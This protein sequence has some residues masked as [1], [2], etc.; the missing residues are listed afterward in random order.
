MT[1]A[2]P[3]ASAVTTPPS[4]TSPTIRRCTRSSAW[5]STRATGDARSP[6]TRSGEAVASR[7]ALHPRARQRAVRSTSLPGRFTWFDDPGFRPRSRTSP[8]TPS[9]APR[10]STTSAADWPLTRSRWTGRC[11]TPR[12]STASPTAGR[13][14]SS[15]STMRSWTA[16][17]RPTR[18]GY[19][20][21]ADRGESVPSASPDAVGPTA[22]P[23]RTGA[24]AARPPSRA[25]VG[26]QPRRV[27]RRDRHTPSRT[28]RRRPADQVARRPD[29][30]PLGS[31]LRLDRRSVRR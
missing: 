8:S 27:R 17:G 7:L 26:P 15:G 6:W 21:T 29:R 3:S 25:R 16:S 20:T 1:G 10:P 18:S 30:P 28:G 12:S 14:W 4:S 31:D 24:A 5:C 13:P 23:G 2:C 19:F 22:D 9:T 11:G